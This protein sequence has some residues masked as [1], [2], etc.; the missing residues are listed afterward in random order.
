MLEDLFDKKNINFGKSSSVL[1][2]VD[3]YGRTV[4]EIT[5]K[6]TLSDYDLYL[7][8]GKKQKD[9]FINAAFYNE[10]GKELGDFEEVYPFNEDGLAIVKSKYKNFFGQY[11]FFTKKGKTLG[12]PFKSI[13]E[14]K[15]SNSKDLLEAIEIIGAN[16][17]KYATKEIL[18]DESQ[19][20][21]YKEALKKYIFSTGVVYMDDKTEEELKSIVKKEYDLF[22]SLFEEKT[23]TI[24]KDKET[25]RNNIINY[26]DDLIK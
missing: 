3:K 17:I 26:I 19:M 8:A 25:K 12:T 1:G 9:K 22:N 4:V 21:K 24:T 7:L 18:L 5:H 23:K 20:P 13:D 6:H 16:A 15:L 14:A 11:S 2:L 10:K